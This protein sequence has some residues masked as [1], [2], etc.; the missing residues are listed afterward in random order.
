MN[1]KKIEIS[2]KQKITPFLMRHNEL[3]CEV[4]FVN[5]LLWQSLYKSCYCIEDDILYIKSHSSKGD[6]Y[7]LPFGDVSH[8]MKKIIEHQGCLPDIWAQEGPRFNSFKSLY[9]HCYDFYEIRD[10]FDYIYNSSDLINL[11][12]K[13]YHSKRNHISAFSKRFDW[14]YEQIGLENIKNIRTCANAWYEQYGNDLSKE[15]KSERNGIDMMLQKMEQLD[16]IGGAIFVDDMAVAFTLGAPINQQVFN[17][18]IEKA[19]PGFESA[20]TLINREFAA[21]NL[22]SYKYINRENDMG[23]EGLRKAK[24]SYKPQIILPKYL[25]TKKENV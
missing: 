13:K 17:I 14:R 19:I 18:H 16:I 20:Y 23:I 12:G 24:L 7:S 21:R 1:F 8:G 25:C 6:A 9:R 3:T 2:D 10:E 4:S 22:A 15:L 11:S 5:L